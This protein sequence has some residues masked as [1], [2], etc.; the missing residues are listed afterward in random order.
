MVAHTRAV[1]RLLRVAAHRQNERGLRRAAAGSGASADDSRSH[2]APDRGPG[3]TTPSVDV[4]VVNWNSKA[5]TLACLAAIEPQLAEVHGSVVTVVDNGS[6]DGSIAEITTKYPRARFVPL[7]TNR[8]FT[9]GLSAALATSRARNVVFLNNDA[10]PEH[11]WLAA[12]TRA[13]DDAPNDVVSA[14]GRIISI[15]GERIDFIGGMLTFDGHAFQEGFRMPLGAKP[16]P[17]SGDEIL[18]ACG[19]NMISRREALLDLGGLDD[20]YFAYLED[21]DFGWRTWI[22]GKR[23]I[24]E[25]RA[26]VRHASSATSDRLGNFERGVLFERNALQTVL[27]NLEN[28]R[29]SAGSIFFTY[30]HRL[31][32]YATTRNTRASELTREPF[33]GSAAES[34]QRRS[35]RQRIARKIKG[36]EP[37]AALD[38]PLTTMQFRAF[39]WIMRNESRIAEKRERVQA[40]RRRSDR[41]IFDRFPMHFVPTYPGDESLM[42]GAL[43]RIL[44][45]E[46]PSVERKLDEIIKP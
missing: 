43:F 25:P 27:K 26:S 38:D 7:G 40:T 11:G 6:T 37:L 28:L 31:H 18:F 3:L 33:N 12:I 9:G 17:K 34:G 29:E 1:D 20:D 44:R 2:Q 36:P 45:S 13:I 42:S 23:V 8:G 4:I 15:D 10:I 41:E 32:H 16:E 30:L 39:D 5:H 22:A 14:G 24:F 35:T 21:V 46:L 19:G